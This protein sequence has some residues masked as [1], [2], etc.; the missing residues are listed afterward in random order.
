LP[1]GSLHFQLG[2]PAN[3]GFGFG[4]AKIGEWGQMRK[5]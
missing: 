3:P 4:V 2:N 5:P 1:N